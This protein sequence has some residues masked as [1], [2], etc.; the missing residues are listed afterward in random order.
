MKKISGALAVVVLSFILLTAGARAGEAATN[1]TA[2][3]T[4][5]STDL[6]LTIPALSFSGSL[7][8]ASLKYHYSTDSH[9]WFYVLNAAGATQD[10]ANPATLSLNASNAYI[11]HIPILLYQNISYKVDLEYVPYTDGLVWF[12]VIS[13]VQN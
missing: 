10:C 5:S 8:S 1:C 7:Y 12:K 3:L 6:T 13:A 9:I 2:T 4:G 11:L